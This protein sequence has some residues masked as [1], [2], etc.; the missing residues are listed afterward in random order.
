[1]ADKSNK[2]TTT[3]LN[4]ILDLKDRIKQ[5]ETLGNDLVN[6]IEKAYWQGGLYSATIHMRLSVNS[7]RNVVNVVPV[8]TCETC[9]QKLPIPQS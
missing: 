4:R 2:I 3:T 1:M 5:L 6:S 7:W 9:H 8:T